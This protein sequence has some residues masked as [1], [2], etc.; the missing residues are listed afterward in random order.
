MR[1]GRDERLDIMARFPMAGHDVWTGRPSGACGG[2]SWLLDQ[3]GVPTSAADG[4]TLCLSTL[5][6]DRIA[7]T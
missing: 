1:R 3:I 6:D 5:G 4:R 7:T 2:F